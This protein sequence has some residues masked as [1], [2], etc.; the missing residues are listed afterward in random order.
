MAR[1]VDYTTEDLHGTPVYSFLDET[2]ATSGPLYGDMA[3]ELRRG[4]DSYKAFQASLPDNRLAS[5]GPAGFESEEAGMSVTGAPRSLS[6]PVAA[7]P[8]VSPNVPPSAGAPPAPPL[9]QQP[10]GVP[11]NSP[12]QSAQ[13]APGM[14][15]V[16][17]FINRPVTSAGVSQA[18]LQRKAGQGVAIPK[19]SDETVEGAAPYDADA[20]LARG[21]ANVD[22]RLAKQDQA[23]VFAARAERDAQ[24]L[25]QQAYMQQ[26]RAHR[27]QQKLAHVEQGVRADMETAQE[28]RRQAMAQQV[29]P[30]HLFSGV[31]GTIGAIASI[32]GQGMGAYA[33]AKLGGPNFAQQI[34]QAAIDRDVHAQ[35]VNIRNN[36]ETANNQLAE[37]YQRLGNMEQSKAVLRQMQSDW[38]STQMGSIAARDKAQDVQLAHQEWEAQNQAAR[39]EEERKFLAESYGKHT[40][41]VSQEFAYPQ[42]GGTRAPTLAEQRARVGLLKDIGELDKD[43]AATDKTRADT[44]K[45]RAEARKTGFEAE[46]IAGGELQTD[47]QKKYNEQI[48]SIDSTKNRLLAIAR[49]HGYKLDPSTGELSGGSFP[50]DLPS[51]GVNTA[52]VTKF[53]TDLTAVGRMFAGVINKGGE[54]SPDLLERVTPRSGSRDSPVEAQF[55]SIWQTLQQEEAAIKAGATGK[56]RAGREAERAKVGVENNAAAAPRI[57]PR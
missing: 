17:T 2:G 56:A 1:L 15:D 9:P 31:S 22:L 50:A 7:P 25:E 33:A 37:I 24:V 51:A 40:M 41:R 8:N 11:A 39:A 55:Q 44:E 53:N 19:G 21:A 48:Q 35:E 18:Q 38:V 54:P 27:E 43:A 6:A 26:V 57:T 3:D 4:V 30:T 13:V 49:E 36:R 12:P 32:I 20:A 42:A 46:Q 5:N 34:V 45:S 28:Y 47:V 52:A 10:Q 14:G 29:D 16:A 23:D